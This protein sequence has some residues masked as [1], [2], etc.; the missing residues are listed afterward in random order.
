VTRRER[1]HVWL[2]RPGETLLRKRGTRALRSGGRHGRRN[3][4]KTASDQRLEESL[5]DV[6]EFK[7]IK[8][9]KK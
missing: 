6:T 1:A 5:K 7:K 3:H 9:N 2:R 8:K 4:D